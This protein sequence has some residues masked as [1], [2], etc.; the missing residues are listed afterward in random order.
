MGGIEMTEKI[1][2]T[3]PNISEQTLKEMKKFFMKTSIPRIVEAR[4]TESK[5][6]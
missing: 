1:I 6:A 4:K 5:G 2:V 3:T